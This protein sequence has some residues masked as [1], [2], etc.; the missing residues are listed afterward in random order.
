MRAGPTALDHDSGTRTGTWLVR[1]D[2]LGLA[3]VGGNGA[4]EGVAARVAAD[5][6]REGASVAEALDRGL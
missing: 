2:A 4:G 5:D 6:E 1:G 3:D